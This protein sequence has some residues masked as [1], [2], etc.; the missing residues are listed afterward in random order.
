MIALYIEGMLATINLIII[1]LKQ[2]SSSN[3]TCRFI[4]SRGE[5]ES[6]VN[7]VSEEVI[8]RVPKFLKSIKRISTKLLMSIMTLFT[9]V[10]IIYMETTNVS[11][12][13]GSSYSISFF[14]SYSWVIFG[15]RAFPMSC[16]LSR[17]V[18]R[19]WCLSASPSVFKVGAKVFK[20]F[21]RTS[22]DVPYE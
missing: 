6:L 3:V 18:P 1:V 22:Q 13:F 12:W 10:L 16:L 9:Q 15:P 7:Y 19:W 11:S 14:L 17:Q 2:S 21:G 20:A 5:M 8:S 4:V